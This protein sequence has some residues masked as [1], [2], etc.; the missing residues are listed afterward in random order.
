MSRRSKGPSLYLKERPG[1]E[2]FWYIRDGAKRFATGFSEREHSRAPGKLAK[3]I[4]RTQTPS[5]GEGDPHKIRRRRQLTRA[6][7]RFCS[8]AAPLIAENLA[9][10]DLR[11]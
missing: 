7:R 9:P 2:P 11:R 5:F 1:Y 6:R 4:T 3:Y 8:L 10:A